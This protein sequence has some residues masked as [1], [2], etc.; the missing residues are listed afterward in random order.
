M[1]VQQC[2]LRAS[3]LESL[4]VP[5]F[6]LGLWQRH[7]LLTEDLPDEEAEDGSWP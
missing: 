4:A 5:R 3:C 7:L 6:A 2:C 1:L